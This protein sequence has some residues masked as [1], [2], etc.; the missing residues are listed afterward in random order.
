MR[1]RARAPFVALALGTI[2][3]GLGVHWYASALGPAI[4]DILGDALWAMMIAWW[5]GAL[6]PERA[7]SFRCSVALIVCIGVEVSQLVHTSMLDDLR[8]T[9]VGQLVL[10][11]GFDPRDLVAYSLGVVAA[12][13][14][15]R[16]WRRR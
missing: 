11:S 16:G 14:L 15:E 1:L 6:V 7:L 13:A 4:R 10:G 12:A 5:V 8:R 9:V 3:L 2:A